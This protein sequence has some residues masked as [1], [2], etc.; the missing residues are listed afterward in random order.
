MRL[1]P[2]PAQLK[3]SARHQQAGTRSRAACGKE[4]VHSA[5]PHA[6]IPPE[7]GNTPNTPTIHQPESSGLSLDEIRR[8][9][10]DLIG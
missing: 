2:H 8:I 5:F 1:R 10:L 6:Y 4:H 3:D 9:V 7:L